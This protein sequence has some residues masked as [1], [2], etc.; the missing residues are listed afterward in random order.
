MD[1]EKQPQIQSSGHMVP[2]LEAPDQKE[3]LE[4]AFANA[5]T[6]VSN[7]GWKVVGGALVAGGASFLAYQA[8]MP[9]FTI[10]Q[11]IIG[12]GPNVVPD[13][14]D[15]AKALIAWAAIQLLPVGIE[16][17]F[18]AVFSFFD[19]TPQNTATAQELVHKKR[20]DYTKLERL[21]C[22]FPPKNPQSLKDYIRNLAQPALPAKVTE[23]FWLTG[24]GCSFLFYIEGQLTGN[25]LGIPQSAFEFIFSAGWVVITF[26]T[27]FNKETHPAQNYFVRWICDSSKRKSLIKQTIDPIDRTLETLRYSGLTKEIKTLGTSLRVLEDDYQL[28]EEND[29]EQQEQ[30][31]SDDVDDDNDKDYEAA[32]KRMKRNAKGQYD[33]TWWSRCCSCLPSVFRGWVRVGDAVSKV[34]SPVIATMSAVGKAAVVDRVFYELLALGLSPENATIGGHVAAALASFIILPASI[35]CIPYIQQE[36]DQIWRFLKSKD[37]VGTT[38]GKIP[39][40]LARSGTIVG[41]VLPLSNHIRIHGFTE[42]WGMS[43]PLGMVFI[44]PFAF[45]LEARYAQRLVGPSYDAIFNWVMTGFQF[46]KHKLPFLSCRIIGIDADRSREKGLKVQSSLRILKRNF[47][48]LTDEYLDVVAQSLPQD[49]GEEE[50]DTTDNL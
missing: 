22:F 9:M 46:N 31:E 20:A 45:D 7:F 18:N 16:R 11:D 2:I 38:G 49:K 27:V 30:N 43:Y 19:R 42:R 14:T 32:L 17:S 13:G 44:V 36:V 37:A 5:T 23:M 4:T 3:T 48:E 34:S 39:A 8:G 28:I 15:A 29:G 6:P 26:P 50:G 1:E 40:I 25:T 35:E 33:G 41:I 10:G 12:L 47:S 21:T 24:L